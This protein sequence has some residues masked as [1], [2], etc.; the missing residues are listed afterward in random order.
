VG[1]PRLP[2]PPEAAGSAE[3]VIGALLYLS[4]LT[5][6]RSLGDAPVGAP[7]AIGA[8]GGDGLGEEAARRGRSV[9]KFCSVVSLW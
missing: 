3:K 2:F 9:A 8:V 7:H 5:R 1:D 6:G 4:G